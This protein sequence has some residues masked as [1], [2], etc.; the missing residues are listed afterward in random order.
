[1]DDAAVR[2]YLSSGHGRVSGSVAAAGTGYRVR[3]REPDAA[4]GIG[5]GG[6]VRDLP[7][8]PGAQLVR[9]GG[10]GEQVIATYHAGPGRWVAAPAGVPPVA[11]PAP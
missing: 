10:T 6:H 9:A 2:R 1:M 11:R 8:P 4:G 3:W 5:P 7:L